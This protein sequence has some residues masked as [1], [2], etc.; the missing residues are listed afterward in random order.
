M[1]KH[2]SVVCGFCTMFLETCRKFICWEIEKISRVISCIG[3]FFI[4]IFD[5]III[6]STSVYTDGWKNASILNPHDR[7]RI[8]TTNYISQIYFH[9]PYRYRVFRHWWPGWSHGRTCSLTRSDNF[10]SIAHFISPTNRTT[11]SLWELDN[12]W[13]TRL[14]FD[15]KKMLDFFIFDRIWANNGFFSVRVKFY[16]CFPDQV[17]NFPYEYLVM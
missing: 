17:L 2:Y 3:F 14:N 8:A 11:F 10:I 5:K 9:I 16:R 13:R 15:L 1:Y 6:R 12:H 7:I 4:R